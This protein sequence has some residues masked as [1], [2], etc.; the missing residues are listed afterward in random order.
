MVRLL[1]RWHSNKTSGNSRPVAGL[2]SCGRLFVSDDCFHR[3]GFCFVWLFV[4]L[5]FGATVFVR[6]VAV[7]AAAGL[8]LGGLGGGVLVACMSAA[9]GMR[10]PA[11]WV[12]PSRLNYA[13]RTDARV[14]RCTGYIPDDPKTDPYTPFY[15]GWLGGK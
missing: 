5:K 10:F 8:G 11:P 13:V 2:T 12:E 4:G 14:P 9:I 7:P 3:R 1:P 15:P 6:L